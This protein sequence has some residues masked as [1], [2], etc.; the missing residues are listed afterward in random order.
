MV[1]P[2]VPNRHQKQ[3]RFLAALARGITPAEGAALTRVPLATFYT[4]R[5]KHSRF[6]DAWKRA[7]AYGQT[8]PFPPMAQLA[9]LRLSGPKTH[10]GVVAHGLL[11][12]DNT[13]PG[14]RIAMIDNR[15]LRIRYYTVLSGGDWRED[16]EYSTREP[17][18]EG[19]AWPAPP[20]SPEIE[21]LLPPRPAPSTTVPEHRSGE[22][23]RTD[24]P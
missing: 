10:W 23:T 16:C 1:T 7:V 24:A 15:R 6:R 9:T 19:I 2:P 22:T 14:D 21:R 12:D 17:P 4:W 11:E 18:P 8:P 20:V 13:E 3:M 5:R